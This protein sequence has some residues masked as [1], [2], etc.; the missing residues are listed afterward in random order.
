MKGIVFYILIISV[1]F[2]TL[3]AQ[4]EAKEDSLLNLYNSTE[5]TDS[6]KVFVLGNLVQLFIYNDREKAQA[7]I[8]EMNRFSK[9][10]RNQTG[11]A[12]SNLLQGTI[13]NY[14]EGMD[15][16]AHYY[17]KAYDQ[18]AAIKDTMR[19]IRTGKNLAIID[20]K[21]GEYSDAATK[22]D[23]AIV[24]CKQYSRGKTEIGPLYNMLLL[25]NKNQGHY[26]IALKNGLTAL[27]VLE[28][29]NDQAFKA[30]ALNFLGYIER[31]LGHY[32]KSIEYSLESYEI[33]QKDGNLF[34][35]AQ[36]CNDLGTTY[37]AMKDYDSA[38]KYLLQSIELYKQ[39]GAESGSETAFRNLSVVH[40]EKNEL[41][42][43]MDFLKQSLAY[44]IQEGTPKKLSEVQLEF[45]RNYLLLNRPLRALDYI[46]ES[47]KIADS[48]QTKQLL[49]QGYFE[50]AKAHEQLGLQDI[51]LSDFRIYHLLEDSLLN[52]TRSQ[53][54]EEM[55]I[56]H[57]I[58][59]KEQSLELQKSQ[60]ANLEKDATVN[61]LQ[62]S[63]L[64]LGLAMSL[65]IFGLVYF[66]I[67][68]K[69]KRNRLEKAQQKVLYEKELDY[70]K[71][72]LTA[73]TMHLA[74][75]NEVLAN[76]KERVEG[77]SASPDPSRAYRKLVNTIDIE[78][79][80]DDY[81]ANFKK[82]F[83]QIHTGFNNNVI[84]KYSSV[85]P[86]ELRLMALLK[87]NLS[88]K[89]IANILNI[90]DYGIKKA[91]QRLR[92]KLGLSPDDSLEGLIMKI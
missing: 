50:R 78:L 20:F 49:S 82:Y 9:S 65:V 57:E 56:L 24:L 89:E 66:T 83:E 87:L 59:K 22:I 52:E 21:K 69:L 48:I 28:E 35:L 15:S 62:R 47:I 46:N 91:R 6:A 79:Q 11:I 3:N 19:Q 67:Q 16:A 81:W 85:T 17:Q 7:Y 73:H 70:K 88:S 68:Q 54:M 29:N 60:I 30:E 71:R 5:V 80:D 75:K 40:R 41:D 25:I 2:S 26:Q 8:L 34:F 92:K 55:R 33:H 36:D 27:K 64:S 37:L 39:V 53:Q 77:L 42:K 86:N 61:K 72:E 84:D 12:G 32:D 74:K 23:S 43:S 14:Y 58:E 4:S 76:L 1:S 45:G 51:A 63:I 10:I 13:Y 18:F 31:F 38:E 44:S 90:T